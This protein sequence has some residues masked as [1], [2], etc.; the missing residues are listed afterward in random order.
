MAQHVFYHS[1]D[2]DG[3]CSGAIVKHRFPASSLNPINYNQVFPWEIIKPEDT[4][5]M[6]D[7]GLQ[8]FE[9]MIRLN[10]YCKLVWI[11][12]HISAIKASAVSGEVILGRRDVGKAACE[13]TWAYLYPDSETPKFIHLLGRYDVWD[14]SD[15]SLWDREILPFQYGMRLENTD[16]S[17]NWEFWSNLFKAD[18]TF[19]EKTIKIGKLILSYD[20]ETSARYMRSHAYEIQFEGLRALAVNIGNVSSMF[21]ASMYDPAKHD[22][23]IAYSYIRGQFWGVTLYSDKP[24]VDCSMLAKKRGGG[25]HKGA[26]GFSSKDFPFGRS[27]G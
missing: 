5:F 20:A 9:E 24:E 11:D 2:L 7:F 26:A 8:P 17:K 12:H 4:V 19:Y 14:H 10:A 18:N 13:L 21:F 16:P 27:L 22:I 3:Q 15:Q 6:V 1:A 23:M 25:G